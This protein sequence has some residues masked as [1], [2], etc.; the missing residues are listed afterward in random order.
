MTVLTRAV[1]LA[2]IAAA[3]PNNTSQA[4]SPADVRT[5]LEDLADS[6]VFPEDTGGGISSV[7]LRAF[8]SSTTYTPTSGMAYALVIATGGGASGRGL[9]GSSGGRPGGGAGETTFKLVT[10]A[11]IGASKAVTIGA[12]GTGSTSGGAAGGTTSLGSK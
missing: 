1:L 7:V 5:Q 4:I 9:S 3:L 11:D 2:A 12:G 10:A 6:A 8:T